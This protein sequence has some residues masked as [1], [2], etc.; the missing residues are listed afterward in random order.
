VREIK[1]RSAPIELLPDP[2]TEERA[3]GGDRRPPCEPLR[4]GDADAGVAQ[5]DIHISEEAAGSARGGMGDVYLAE[6]TTL[7]RRVALKI[8]PPEL[9]QSD[10]R[11]ESLVRT[12]LV[13]PTDPLS[14]RSSRLAV[15]LRTACGFCV[16]ISATPSAGHISTAKWWLQPAGERC[17]GHIAFLSSTALT[18]L[19][20]A[21]L[22]PIQR[23][24]GRT[25]TRVNPG[26]WASLRAAYWTFFQS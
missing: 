14:D 13:V 17:S 5:G 23:T 4:I 6:D 10:E 22:A 11:R 26:R 16:G 7:D 2:V 15:H 24:R 21:L 8:L 1:K 3:P 9:A 12:C 18:R 25:A 20:T 19:K